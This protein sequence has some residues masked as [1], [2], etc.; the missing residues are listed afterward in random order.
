MYNQHGCTYTENR[1]QTD[2]DNFCKFDCC[3]NRMNDA[4]I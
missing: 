2:C 4:D 1:Y 3:T